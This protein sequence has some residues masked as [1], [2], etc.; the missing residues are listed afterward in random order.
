VTLGGGPRVTGGTFSFTS[1]SGAQ[2]FPKAGEA[3][4]EFIVRTSDA[5]V[6][7][8]GYNVATNLPSSGFELVQGR[9]YHLT[10]A[11]DVGSTAE[12]GLWVATTSATS[13]TVTYLV[14]T[15]V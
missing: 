10:V 3:A 8:G 11:P 15:K 7:L 9:E 4:I 6:F 12:T 13:V 14:T 1:A 2:N 5:G